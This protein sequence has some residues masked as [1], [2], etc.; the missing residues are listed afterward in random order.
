MNPVTWQK[1]FEV[2]HETIDLEHRTF[3]TLVK[4]L[5]QQVAQ[6]APHDALQRTVSELL[7]YADF[8][9][10]SEE[11][12]M[13]EYGFEGMDA[14]RAAH[15]RL[16]F[17]LREDATSFQWGESSGSELVAFLYRWLVQHTIEEDA[18][19]AMVVKRANMQRW[20]P[21]EG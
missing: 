7:K 18:A 8:H 16:L 1:W 9:F 11:N 15:R 12:V 17:K 6:G 20:F 13:L 19:L 14:H 5:E 10:T 4:K 3:F 21:D 2:G